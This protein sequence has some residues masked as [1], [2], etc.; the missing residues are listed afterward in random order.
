MSQ[1]TAED[2]PLDSSRKGADASSSALY[3]KEL[4]DFARREI[5]AEI[6]GNPKARR[7]GNVDLVL[8]SLFDPDFREDTARDPR[9]I[10][11]RAGFCEHG[12][13][14]M[15][16]IMKLMGHPSIQAL[17]TNFTENASTKYDV[18]SKDII[19]VLRDAIVIDKNSDE[20]THPG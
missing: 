20:D 1:K 7:A 2:I 12:D 3:K 4:M 8:K 17:V 6:E 15:S 19:S 11:R 18:S 10:A 5:V 14:L 13:P 16:K 9:R